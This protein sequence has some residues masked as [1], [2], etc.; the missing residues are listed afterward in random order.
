LPNIAAAELASALRA[1]PASLV[2]RGTAVFAPQE[3]FSGQASKGVARIL[4]VEDDFI[5]ASEIEAVLSDAGY[6]IAGIA[7]SAE[8][9]VRLANAELP[10]L[11]IMDI[12][13]L[14]RMDGVDAALQMFRESGVRCIFATAHH[15]AAMRARAHPAAPLGWLPKPY[16]PHALLAMVK[17]ALAEL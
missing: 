9:A 11:A 12:R 14:G 13:L 8:D 1:H 16:A 10:D 15:D 6:Q 3:D 17:Q 2:P 5:A 7:N 4:I